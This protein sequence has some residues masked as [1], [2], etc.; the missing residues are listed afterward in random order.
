VA[1]LLIFLPLEYG[2]ADVPAG[3]ATAAQAGGAPGVA[4]GAPAALAAGAPGVA[5]GAPV[6]QAAGAPAPPA[7]AAAV[8]AD[9]AVAQQA[10]APKPAS[11]E[12][13]PRAAVT[14]TLTIKVSDR[15][16][17]G[18]GLIKKTEELEGYFAA[19]SDQS[20]T[21]KV[22]VEQVKALLTYAEG[23]GV[24]VDRQ[25]ETQ[26]LGFELDQRK[27]KLASRESMLAKYFG[28]L[29]EAGADGVVQVE[30][31]VTNL[32]SEIEGL[33]GSIQLM[34]HRLRY[35]QVVINFQFRDRAAPAKDGRSSFPWLNTMNLVDLLEDFRRGSHYE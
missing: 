23:L 5:A 14:S 8:T 29:R 15:D 16:Q 4:A 35:A 18:D 13:A 6:A 3:G 28:V 19:R 26:D 30:S 10:A 11:P 25:Y 7:G 20:V 9:P 24:V 33:K 32:V 17:A 2:A 27:T 22:P 12:N 34:E 21:L 31:E 1:G